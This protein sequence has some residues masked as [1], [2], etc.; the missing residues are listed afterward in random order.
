[1]LIAR[2]LRYSNLVNEA[3]PQRRL[4]RTSA[5]ANAPPFIGPIER[6][7]ISNALRLDL[8]DTGRFDAHGRAAIAC[9]CAGI[10][11][12]RLRGVIHQ[13]ELVARQIAM[14]NLEQYAR[15]TDAN[16]LRRRAAI[17]RPQLP[18]TRL[19]RSKCRRQWRSADAGTVTAIPVASSAFKNNNRVIGLHLTTGKAGQRLLSVVRPIALPLLG[20]S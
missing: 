6:R 5:I 14:T 12:H 3:L 8:H 17:K 19:H 2:R 1:M 7:L 10:A 18:L 4:R 20:K 16:G 11:D 15:V 9:R 13:H